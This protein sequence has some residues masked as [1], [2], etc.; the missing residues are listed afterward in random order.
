LVNKLKQREVS[1]I[2]HA[3]KRIKNAQDGQVSS[4]EGESDEE[5]TMEDVSDD[6]LEVSDLRPVQKHLKM[7]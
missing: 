1:K 3:D 6:E 5:D 7:R 2:S 4:S